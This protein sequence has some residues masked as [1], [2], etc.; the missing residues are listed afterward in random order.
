[1]L[2]PFKFIRERRKQLF[3]SLKDGLIPLGLNI[4][5]LVENMLG[6]LLQRW[7]FMSSA[8]KGKFCLATWNHL[9]K[10]LEIGGHDSCV[11]CM[12]S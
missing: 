7:C 1:M 9:G 2:V 12:D 5:D 8:W 10:V 3:R 6:W 11:E 4:K